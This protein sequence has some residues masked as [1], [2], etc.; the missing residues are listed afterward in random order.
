MP[1]RVALAVDIL[2]RD[3]ASGTLR[4]VGNEADKTHSK[5]ASFAGAFAGG[6]LA[7]GVISFGKSSVSAFKE[8]EQAQNRLDF[9]FS[10]F[11]KLADS[12]AKSLRT[13]N[14]QLARKTVYDDDALAS[15][16]AVLAQFGLTG[17]QLERITPLL[18]DYAS[19]TGTDI[20][21]AAT[22]LGRALMGNT[23]ALKAV[24]INYKSTG[25]A[26]QDLTNI[27]AL[28]N[29][30]LK[31]FAEREGKTSAGQAKI[32]GNEYG[33]IQEAVGAHL[34]P[35][36]NNLAGKLLTV[37]DYT[38][39]N[40]AVIKPLVITVGGFA[41]AVWGV[42]KAVG[43]WKATEKAFLAVKTL[44]TGSVV[45][46]GTAATAATAST[47]VLA[48]AET[49]AGASATVAAGE[50]AVLT[51]AETAAGTAAVGTAGRLGTLGLAAKG[52]AGPFAIGTAAAYE[53]V[54]ALAWMD[55]QPDARK[56]LLSGSKTA[57]IKLPGKPSGTITFGDGHT[58]VADGSGREVG[59][60]PS[61]P[62][63]N[64]RLSPDRSPSG[65][66]RH[67]RR[68]GNIEA[69]RL[70]MAGEEGPELIVPKGRG[71]VL[72]AK[73]TRHALNVNR[74]ARLDT[75]QIRDRRHDPLRLFTTSDNPRP[76][77]ALTPPGMI[78]YYV[79]N[80]R[81]NLDGKVI[82]R[83]QTR[84]TNARVSR[85]HLAPGYL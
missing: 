85:G 46:E 28:L 39:R 59:R 33:E 57:T 74:H 31:G 19:A 50:L 18:A 13:L 55:D 45:A 81:I 52:L 35:A 3:R 73:Q 30:K 76:R 29:A 2:A 21:T 38:Q 61:G 40:S 48:A 82:G 4:K 16:Q 23:R 62:A 79:V 44:F 20:P 63:P 32:L 22:N 67:R 70:Y 72:T 51:T 53:F 54:K 75:S 7:A 69:G 47:T 65:P 68:G 6:A 8:A 83:A 10:K 9:A 26:A 77:S 41:A 11:P 66:V 27:Q 15:G 43:A 60:A 56:N 1:S 37:I 34:V 58:Y 42:N 84:R 12:N 64:P 71:T 24:G 17:K 49:A 36:L 14:T 5:V 80:T 25:N 78:D